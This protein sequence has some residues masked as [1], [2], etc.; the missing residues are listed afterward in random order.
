MTAWIHNVLFFHALALVALGILLRQAVQRSAGSVAEKAFVGLAA[1][2]LAWVLTDAVYSVLA[3]EFGI[4][5]APLGAVAGVSTL[6]MAGAIYLFCEYFPDSVEVDPRAARARHLRMGIALGITPIFAAV[7]FTDRWIVDRR[8]VDGV[9]LWTPGQLFV[10]PSLWAV[11]LIVVGFV[12]LAGKY[13]GLGSPRDR[14]QLQFFFVGMLL[15]L[16]LALLFA[17]VLPLVGTA[18]FHFLGPDSSMVLNAML[19]YSL[20]FNRL[21]DLRTAA[22]QILPVLCL[23]V[24]G[25][26]LFF[27]LAQAAALWNPGNPNPG[28]P[29]YVLIGLCI[30]CAAV[31]GH[32]LQPWVE[33]RLGAQR[34]DPWESFRRLCFS[35]VLDPTD[36]SLRVFMERLLAHISRETGARGGF[37]LTLDRFGRPAVVSGGAASPSAGSRRFLIRLQRLRA[38]APAAFRLLDTVFMPE[39]GEGRPFAGIPGGK[40]HRR[41]LAAL[42]SLR[43]DL[44]ARG[45]H[46]F[47][48]LILNKEICGYLGLAARKSEEPYWQGDVRFLESIRLPLALAL[49]NQTYYVELSEL[50]SEA[51]QEVQK[52]AAVIADRVPVRHIVGERT[53][54]YRSAGMVAVMDTCR[55]YA[56]HGHPVLITGETG[57]GKEF[58]ARFLHAEGATADRPFVALNCAAIPASLWEAEVFGHAKGACTG[59]SADRKGAVVRAA[60]GTLF[61]DEVGETPL[62]M[63]SKLLRLF[64]EGTFLPPGSDREV[65][66]TCRFVLAT[67]RDLEEMISRDQF[68]SD[69]YYRINVFPVELVPLR[70]RPED[71]EPLVEHFL[72]R[73]APELG[74]PARHTSEEALEILLRHDWPGNVRELENVILRATAG[75]AHSVLGPEDLPPLRTTRAGSQKEQFRRVESA[76]SRSVQTA[77]R[78]AGQAD[79]SFDSLLRD[80]RRRVIEEALQKARGNKA[81]AA[82][83]L[84]MNRTRLNYQIRELGLER[85]AKEERRK[86]RA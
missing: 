54:V 53:M 9:S 6:F 52:L 34:R 44:K 49:R 5:S 42:A 35:G 69:L 24:L 61:L 16:P 31:F 40:E 56:G 57:T 79:V 83:L 68:R 7:Q 30:G 65:T 25:A 47:T 11:F 38:F 4:I 10:F 77:R 82:R 36:E 85:A 33:K 81:K 84:G 51:E 23:S 74:S 62:E 48:P 39:H 73:Y 64:Q 27:S 45:I 17:F 14:K 72:T 78:T 19:L 21:L 28:V 86:K 26:T 41:I 13:R 66:A 12:L 2:S 71:I 59:A 80:Y 18:R 32:R 15:N 76:T 1:A 37:L 58:I 22:L 70:E 55:Q 46:A 29:F 43:Q 3:V 8:V 75:A 20:L 50:R 63:Q 67:N 60:G